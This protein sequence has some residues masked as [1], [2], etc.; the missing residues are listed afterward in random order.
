MSA[1]SNQGSIWC[2]EGFQTQLSD[3]SLYAVCYCM[4]SLKLYYFLIEHTIP[5]AHVVMLH[6]PVESPSHHLRV[7]CVCLGFHI[8]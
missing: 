7:G 6:N 5:P 2:V 3:I 8:V 1:D 4:D